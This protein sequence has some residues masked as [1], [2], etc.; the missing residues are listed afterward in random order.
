M[1]LDMAAFSS[2]SLAGVKLIG[3]A[4]SCASLSVI[5]L[6]RPERATG[7][8]FK[9]RHDRVV[10]LHAVIVLDLVAPPIT[11]AVL[12]PK[13]NGRRVRRVVLDCRRDDDL[14]IDD[15]YVVL[16]VRVADCTVDQRLLDALGVEIVLAPSQCFLELRVLV[17]PPG[18]RG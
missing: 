10:R 16:R 7:N 6:L 12:Q 11:L 2:S 15:T 4:A 3:S 18:D 5:A 14:A 1:G 13:N 9:Q 17:L 8:P